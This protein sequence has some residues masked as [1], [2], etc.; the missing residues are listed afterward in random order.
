MP[1]ANAGPASGLGVEAQM[2][3]TVA[4]VDVNFA[5]HGE[6]SPPLPSKILD[7]LIITWLLASKL[8]QQPGA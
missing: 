7:G 2:F 6:L 1:M 3:C 5:H 4:P 8:Q